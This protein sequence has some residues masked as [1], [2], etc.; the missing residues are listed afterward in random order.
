MRQAQK[1][2]ECFGTQAFDGAG[3]SGSLLAACAA[4][5]KQYKQ[6]KGQREGR[7]VI[8][9]RWQVIAVLHCSRRAKGYDHDGFRV[10]HYRHDALVEPLSEDFDPPAVMSV[11]LRRF[12]LADAPDNPVQQPDVSIVFI[13]RPRNSPLT[14]SLHN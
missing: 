6:Q 4:S 8:N 9:T 13:C 2:S 11:V 12:T 14:E 1:R 7:E 10:S 5:C 3:W